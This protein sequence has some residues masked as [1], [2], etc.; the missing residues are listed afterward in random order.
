MGCADQGDAD[1]VWNLSRFIESIRNKI[2]SLKWE[3]I[4]ESKYSVVF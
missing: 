1:L 3:R 4:F 2:R